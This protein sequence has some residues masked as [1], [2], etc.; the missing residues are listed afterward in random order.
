MAKERTERRR[1]SADTRRIITGD[2][3][4]NRQGALVKFQAVKID[5]DK[6]R[7]IKETVMDTMRPKQVEA[8]AKGMNEETLEVIRLKGREQKPR[9][10]LLMGE[11]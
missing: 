5:S 4:R 10:A 2:L 11:G 7:G 1:M 9:K 3:M 8:M 6:A